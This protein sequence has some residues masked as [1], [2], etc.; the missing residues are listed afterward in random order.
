MHAAPEP[1]CKRFPRGSKVAKTPDSMGET[2][3]VQGSTTA[4]PV[5]RRRAKATATSS[6]VR[7]LAAV[8]AGVAVF[9]LG[10]GFGFAGSADRLADGVTIAGIDVGGLSPGAAKAMLAERA[11]HDA[12]TPVRFTAGGRSWQIRPNELGVEEDWNA[13][14]DEGWRVE[15]EATRE[16]IIARAKD[17][18]MKAFEQPDTCLKMV[19]IQ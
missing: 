13:A 5:G 7:L 12:N 9:L 2:L 18:A 10:V 14:V 16:R 4:A 1:V 15:S 3:S 19:G 8:A 6:R 17:C 11:E